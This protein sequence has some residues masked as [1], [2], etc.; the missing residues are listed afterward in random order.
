MAFNLGD[1]ISAVKNV[2]FSQDFMKNNRDLAAIQTDD[3]TRGV[4]SA[5]VLDQNFKISRLKSDWNTYF[6]KLTDISI[7]E[8]HWNHENLSGLIRLKNFLLVATNQNHNNDPTN[9]PLTPIGGGVIDNIILQIANG[10]GQYVS[11]G[12]IYIYSAGG[13]PSVSS[14][15]ELNFLKSKGWTITIDNVIQ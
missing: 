1:G 9:N 12:T 8:D 6:T 10:S 5:C 7:N 14:I 3:I 4:Y 2:S 15:N 11:G 13:R